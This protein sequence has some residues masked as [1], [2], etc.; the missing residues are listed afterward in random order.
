MA[1]LPNQV[2]TMH[3]TVKDE[4]GETV[5]ATSPESPF[6]FITGHQQV[7]PKF[8]EK[9]KGMLLGS[10]STLE[11]EAKDAYGDYRDELI[12]VVERT[13][14][15]AEMDLEAGMP[16]HARTQDD[17]MIPGIIKSIEGEQVTVDFNHAKAG[18]KLTFEMELLDVREATPEELSHG[19]VHGAGGHHH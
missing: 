10:K 9:V 11:L 7:L 12:Q 17:Q 18:K 15:P 3:Y 6:A 4:N 16:F 8:E 2:I 14:F 5:D 13:A 19:H 1:I